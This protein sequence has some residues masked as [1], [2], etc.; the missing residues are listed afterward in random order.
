MHDSW[1]EK[2]LVS[3][4]AAFVGK[5]SPLL[6][7]IILVNALGQEVLF[8]LFSYRITSGVVCCVR[9]WKSRVVVSAVEHYFSVTAL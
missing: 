1:L 8:I 4:F 5:V 6:V 9:M 7:N 3:L 2:L